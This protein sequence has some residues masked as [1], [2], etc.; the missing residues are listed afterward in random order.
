M[1]CE[2]RGSTGSRCQPV[3]LLLL[4]IDDQPAELQHLL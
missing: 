2:K 3:Q 1:A 4:P